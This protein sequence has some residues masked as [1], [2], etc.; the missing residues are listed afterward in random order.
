MIPILYE[1][2][3]TSFLNN[4]ICRLRDCIRCECPEER[5]G[6]FEVEFEYPT[7]GAH[8]NDIK[9]GRIIAVEHDE[10]GEIEPFDIISCSRDINGVVT[11]RAQHI[12]YRQKGI[13]VTNSGNPTLQTAFMWLKQTNT[14]PNPFF[15]F[16]DID[17]DARVAAFDGTPRTVREVLGGVEGSI[18]DS[19]GGEYEW[20]KFNV[21]LWKS[22]GQE[23]NITIR[24]GVNMMDFKDEMDY[25]DA[26][27]A[28]VPYWSNGETVVVGDIATSDDEGYGGRVYCVPL[29]LSDKY[30][31]QP[32]PLTLRSAARA[33]IKSNQTYLPTRTISIDFVRLQDS[34]EYR[35]YSALQQCKLC[36]SLRVV[37]PRYGV[38]GVFKIVKTVWNV[39][40]ERYDKMELGNPSISLAEALGIK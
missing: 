9:L 22:R 31:E 19:C 25:S 14:P 16:T 26:Y 36:D 30:E 35:Q 21:N 3:E 17:T 13:V 11:F 5:N 4:G 23:K 10:T 24:Y 12:S 32:D 2:N 7:T 28:A 20:N 37:F 39:L 27:T 6:L 34:E 33:Y 40:L 8:Y 29:D 15:Y 1:S 18:L 38:D